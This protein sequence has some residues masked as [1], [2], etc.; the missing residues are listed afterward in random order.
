MIELIFTIIVGIVL[1]SFLGFLFLLCSSDNVTFLFRSRF[2]FVNPVYF[3]KNSDLNIFESIFV[4]TFMGLICP[5][6]TIIYWICKL[7]RFWV[8]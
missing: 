7:F 3:Y 5:I 4:S 1:W 2:E 8:N 6:G